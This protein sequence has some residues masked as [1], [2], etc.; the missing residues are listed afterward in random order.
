MAA[1]NK[2]VEIPAPTA[3]SVKATSTASRLTNMAA[4]I[5]E[6]APVITI[7]ANKRLV[8]RTM[9]AITTIIVTKKILIIT[10]LMMMPSWF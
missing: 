4:E 1:S 8:R 3:A 2:T 5:R 10:M 9:T 7:A 6:Y